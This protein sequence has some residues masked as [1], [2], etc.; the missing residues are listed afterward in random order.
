MNWLISYGKKIILHL[1]SCQMTEEDIQN[2]QNHVVDRETGDSQKDA[3]YLFAE[4]FV[5]QGPQ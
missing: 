5:C 4:F 2:L 1:N 3:V